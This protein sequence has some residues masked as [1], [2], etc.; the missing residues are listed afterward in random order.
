[1]PKKKPKFKSKKKRRVKTPGTKTR[2]N[3]QFIDRSSINHS[4]FSFLSHES[5]NVF[6]FSMFIINIFDKCKDSIFEDVYNLL[7]DGC[8]DDIHT[9]EEYIY[10]DF[11]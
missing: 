9:I 8:F 5:K 2:T 11:E 7:I 10:E 6:N 4:I 3:S 1:M